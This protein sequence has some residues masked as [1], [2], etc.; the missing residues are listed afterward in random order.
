M[1]SMYLFET[2]DYGVVVSVYPSGEFEG[3]ECYGVFNKVTKVTEIYVNLLPKAIYLAREAQDFL[4][5][6]RLA[7]KPKPNQLMLL[8]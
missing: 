5:E 1:S 3:Q 8:H 6:V 2:L 7:D 4:D